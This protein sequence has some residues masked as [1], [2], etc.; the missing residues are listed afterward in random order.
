MVMAKFTVDTANKL[1]IAKV[2]VITFDAKVDLYSEAKVHWI[3]DDT[4]N[5]FRF[6]F[7]SPTT[8]ST[9]VQGGPEIDPIAGTS[10]PTYLFLESGW[11]VRP[12]EADHVLAVT[13]AIL[14]V[15]GGGDPFVDTLGDFT[16]RVNFQ[17][18]VQAIGIAVGGSGLSAAEAALLRDIHKRLALNVTDPW[19]E[20]P[21]TSR[22]VSG[23]II[24]EN[25]G[26]GVN[27]IT[28]TRKP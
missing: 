23:D 14:L 2:G 9:T 18:P 10:I 26:D 24:I 3:T 13:G 15:Q 11:R 17:Q 12:D 21:S 6:P 7:I 16:V 19:I 28:G 27:I 25:T 5:K 22:S 8:G 4:A 1:F 20:T